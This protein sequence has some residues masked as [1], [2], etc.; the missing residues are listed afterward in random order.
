MATYFY[1]EKYD[2]YARL[3][4]G[5]TRKIYC[6]TFLGFS[7]WYILENGRKRCVEFKENFELK[8]TDIYLD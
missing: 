1:N 5:K 2:A 4:N 8:I 6:S 3:E 7:D